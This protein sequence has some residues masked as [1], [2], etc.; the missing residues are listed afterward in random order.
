M[1]QIMETIP[2]RANVLPPHQY[3]FQIEERWLYMPLRI[4]RLP[5]HVDNFGLLWAV[6]YHEERLHHEADNAKSAH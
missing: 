3:R 5:P 2:F 1:K 4:F 6:R